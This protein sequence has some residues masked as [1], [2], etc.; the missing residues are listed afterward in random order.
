MLKKVD[1]YD[2]IN[3]RVRWDVMNNNLLISTAMLSAYWEKEKKD[4]LDLM[5]PFLKYS[6]GKTT[7]VGESLDLTGMISY[8]KKE[9]GYETMPMHVFSV[10]LNR[11]SPEFLDKKRDKYTLKKSLDEDIMK[12]EKG[13]ALFEEHRSKVVTALLEYLNSQQS[14]KRSYTP[15]STMAA[16]ISFFAT[17][18]MCIIKDTALLDLLKKRDDHQKYYIAQFIVEEY[19]KKTE[20]FSYIEDMVKGFFVS[21][22]ISI[23]PQN[24]DVAQSKFQGLNCY[25]DTRMVINALGL[26]LP[27]EKI[28][29]LELLTMLKEKGAELFCFEHNVQE[30]L[31]III[32]YKHGLNNPYCNNFH[33]TLEAWDSQNYTVSDVDRYL[34][35]LRT[36]ISHLGITIIERPTV[37]EVDS[38]PFSDTE[39]INCINDNMRY[40]NREAIETDVQ[41]VASILLLRDGYKNT[42][43]EKCKYVFVTS[44]VHLTNVV[45]SFLLKNS[46]CDF[47]NETMPIITDIDLS[48]IVWLK[49]YSSHK[50]FPRQ[51]LIEQSLTALEPTP[52]MMTT[53]F[54][55]VDRLVFEGGITADEAAII[56]ADSYCKKELSGLVK[57]DADSITVD[58]VYTIRE[59]LKSKYI[60]D[61]NKISEL[62]YQKYAEQKNENRQIITNALQEIESTG[63]SVFR[64]AQ[65]TLKIISVSLFATACVGLLIVTLLSWDSVSV[66]IPTGILS[67][68]SFWGAIESLYAKKGLVN[69]CINRISSCCADKAKDSKKDEYEKIL[70]SLTRYTDIEI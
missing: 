23:Q 67:L 48:S 5:M 26:H 65:K 64:S 34:S 1:K 57:G 3:I 27:E 40:S 2:I 39:L 15:D 33:Q 38:Y 11:M 18:G 4:I 43:I 60:G 12:F 50:D 9:F 32:A 8:F 47:H 17:N 25:I 10:L 19:K 30:I 49:C 56:R 36:K 31:S 53:F 7:K 62:N 46:I 52:T 55:M 45:N 44:N 24:M 68:V 66:C 61:A 28:S 20:V 59:K 37:T 70:G 51:K 16:L 63:K 21:T 54:E 29:S 35:I 42:E 69:R 13:H 22:A 14:L 6:I 41:S 58:T